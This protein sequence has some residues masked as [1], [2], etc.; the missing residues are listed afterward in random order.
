MSKGLSKVWSLFH[1][2]LV[3][4]CFHLSFPSIPMAAVVETESQILGI[5][6]LF[7]CHY[8]THSLLSLLE[9]EE[10]A[11][12]IGIKSKI[13]IVVFYTCS[14]NIR[15]ADTAFLQESLIPVWSSLVTAFVQAY[16]QAFKFSL[17]SS[18]SVSKNLILIIFDRTD[19]LTDSY[20]TASAFFY[21]DAVYHPW[22]KVRQRNYRH[23]SWIRDTVSPI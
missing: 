4:S 18:L 21:S 1:S 9:W 8:L 2:V 13:K 14:Q 15:M 19:R 11:V 16:L 5:W 3:N 6:L 20:M 12:H 23:P 7:C 17:Y 22:G 10:R